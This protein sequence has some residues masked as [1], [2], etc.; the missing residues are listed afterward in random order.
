[1]EKPIQSLAKNIL[2]CPILLFYFSCLPC[3][4]GVVEVGGPSLLVFL[5]DFY[6]IVGF[7]SLIFISLFWGGFDC[8]F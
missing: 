8:I 2:N 6:L 4:Y 1:M 7:F 5:S 3:F